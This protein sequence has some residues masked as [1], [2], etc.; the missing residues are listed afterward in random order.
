MM[1]TRRG[2]GLVAGAAA[3]GAA[4]TG[5]GCSRSSGTRAAG[6]APTAGTA[7]EGA[8][9][10]GT[11]IADVIADPLLG[12]Y[13]RLLFPITMNTPGPADTL[14][15][16]G[17]LL[18][19]YTHVD[20]NATVDVVNDVLLRRR[21]GETVFHDIY[22][23]AEK[24]ADPTLEDT[25]L[26]VFPAQGAPDGGSGRVA[27]CCAG[28][29]FAYV[30]SI[31]DSMPHALWLSR[32]GFTAFALQYRPDPRLGCQDLA[33]A[34]SHVHARAAEFG[35][36]PTGY[37]LWGGSAGARL[38]AA[39]GA[40]GPAAFGGDDLPAAGAVVMQYTGLREVTGTEPPTYAC[41][42]TADAIAPWR[43]MKS[44]LDSIAAAGTPTEFHSYEGLPHGFGL[45][46]GTVA[47]GWIE[48]AAAFWR[49]QIDAAAT[50]T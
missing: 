29:G 7:G 2:L 10:G 24:S 3:T 6:A 30:A 34:V 39:V 28:G 19:W 4:L 35:V 49:A 36:D 50:G 18:A 5:A 25:G 48:G 26:F 45:G 42:G 27:L 47:E 20:V 9:N 38:A 43:T 13:G 12:D 41:V 32:H 44:R 46:V 15:D 22:T 23:D 40:R 17:G 14:A 37:S 8:V 11:L 16:V 21:A 1:L 33:R 31:H